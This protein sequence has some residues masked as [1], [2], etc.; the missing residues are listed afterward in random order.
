MRKVIPTLPSIDVL[1]YHKDSTGEGGSR[2]YIMGRKWLK[3][4]LDHFPATG[5]LIITDGSN[6]GNQLFPKMIRPGGYFRKVWG[7]R[8][9][10]APDEKWRED[11][12]L[13]TIDVEKVAPY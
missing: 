12:G 3:L 5:G 11:Y 2:I 9:S 1:F 13:R 4:I 6:T 8:F 7:F 10:L